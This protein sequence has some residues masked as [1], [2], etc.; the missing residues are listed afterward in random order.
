[1]SI[2]NIT[3][4]VHPIKFLDFR[5]DLLICRF[6]TCA[7]SVAVKTAT[8]PAQVKIDQSYDLSEE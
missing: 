1:M 8:L 5:L 7:E 3:V 6:F 2:D 4:I